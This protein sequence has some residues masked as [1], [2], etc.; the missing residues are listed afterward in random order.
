MKYIGQTTDEAMRHMLASYRHSF[1]ERVARYTKKDNGHWIWT[2]STNGKY[3]VLS[4]VDRGVNT[5]IFVHRALY[6]VKVGFPEPGLEL[7]H[8]CRITRCVRPSH[9]EP[10]TPDVNRAR[11]LASAERARHVRIVR[12]RS[13]KRNE[14]DAEMEALLAS[15]N[16]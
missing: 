11:Y 7:D 9:L 5:N 1:L 3:A 8:T 16:D 14:T 10:V 4:V 2:G 15:I 6:I 13:A 12:K